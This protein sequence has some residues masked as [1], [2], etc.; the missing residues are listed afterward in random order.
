MTLGEPHIHHESVDSTN[1]LA[2]QLA[3]E[4]ATHGTTVTA[5]EQ[6][7]GRGRQG[8]QWIAPPGESLLMSVIVRPMVPRLQ[9]APLAAGLAVADVCEE[10]AGVQP[11]VKWPNDVLIDGRK[12]AG[13][14]LEARPDPELERSWMVI[15]IGL[16]TSLD[17]DALPEELRERAV[18]LNL[19]PETDVLGPLLE[20]LEERLSADPEETIAA[21]RTRDALHGRDVEWQDGSGLAR[22]IDDEGNLLVLSCG[23]GI[24]TLRAGEVH[25]KPA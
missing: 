15:G 22:G 5:D 21:W 6:T 11:K 8:R 10:L 7:A 14:L 18:S 17:V 16:N 1:A 24:R 2:K 3:E 4:G 12:V 23:G 19:P 9:L 25:L 20:R 13:I